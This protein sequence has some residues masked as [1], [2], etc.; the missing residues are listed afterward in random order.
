MFGYEN[1]GAYKL[2]ILTYK[3]SPISLIYYLKCYRRT[4]EKSRFNSD[5]GT[6]LILIKRLLVT[7]MIKKNSSN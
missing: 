1:L 6:F 7:K 4:F 5:N 2:Q 3:C